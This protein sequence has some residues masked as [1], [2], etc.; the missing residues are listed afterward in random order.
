MHKLVLI[1][2]YTDINWQYYHLYDNH[3]YCKY[4]ITFILITYQ[5]YYYSSFFQF[6]KWLLSLI[7]Y[8]LPIIAYTAIAIIVH[9]VLNYGKVL[10]WCFLKFLSLI[11]FATLKDNNIHTEELFYVFILYPGMHAGAEKISYDIFWWSTFTQHISHKKFVFKGSLSL[12]APSRPRI[13]HILIIT[14][15]YATLFNS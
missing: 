14:F 13:W 3:C 15:F 11:D 5:C 2:H 9:I 7:L 4:F 12:H 1:Y 10:Q 8:F 6:C